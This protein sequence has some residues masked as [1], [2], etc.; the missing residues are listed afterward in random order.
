M[1]ILQKAKHKASAREQIDIKGVQ[2]GVLMLAKHEYRAVLEVSSVNFELKSEDEQDALIFI[3]HIQER[4]KK[5]V[6]VAPAFG[7]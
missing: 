1:S 3:F 4:R 7:G 6:D 5:L 2:D